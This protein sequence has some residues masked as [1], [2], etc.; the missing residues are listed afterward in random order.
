[1][2]KKRRGYKMKS[3]IELGLMIVVIV[4]LNLLGGQYYK[5][6][7]LTKEKRYT[8]S[9]TSKNL[10]AQVNEEMLIKVYL[11]GDVSP[12][13]K[14]LKNAVRD[15][16][17]EYRDLSEKNIVYEFKNP[18][19]AAGKDDQQGI[20]QLMAQKGITPYNDLQDKG[21]QEQSVKWIIPGAEVFYQGKEYVWNFL[22]TRSGSA[23]E[24]SIN[25]SIENLEYE[26]SNIL[27]KCVLPKKKKI[28]FLE[29]HGE[30]REE[31][32]ADFALELNDY[33]E[34]QRLNINIEDTSAM[35][36]YALII[37]EENDATK[38]IN[39]VQTSL[40]VFDGLVIAKPQSDITKMESYFIDQYIMKGGKVMWLIDPIIADMDSIE[41]YGKILAPSRNLELIQTQLFNY[42]VRMHNDILLDKT[43]NDIKVV[44]PFQQN[45]MRAFPWVYFPVFFPK[46]EHPIMRNLEGVWGQ[47]SS[48]MKLLS[49]ENLT[50]TPLLISSNGTK[51]AKAPATI[52]I[53][54]IGLLSNKEYVNSFTGGSQVSGALLEGEFPSY[55]ARRKQLSDIQLIKQSPK[56]KM[57]VISDGDIIRNHVSSK[58]EVSPLGF[59]R[60]TSRTFANKKFLLNCIDYLIDDSGLIEVRSKEIK[61]RLLDRVEVAE[62]RSFWQILNMGLPI[63]LILIFGVINSFIRKKKY[64]S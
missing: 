49:K 4:I 34:I 19:E 16:L 59:D 56:S 22:S 35:R 10:S 29:G 39:A 46:N 15:I 31:D 48:T 40:N 13:F 9:E 27:R 14:Q 47:F 7:D 17:N 57:I 28:A 25:G 32:V 36:R 38:L 51:V 50:S 24:E 5:R 58:G 23:K 60:N 33:Y 11:D 53:S 20:L 26:F 3:F 44:S 6:F 30:L 42:G 41:K 43:C 62:N 21:I 45:E 37:K 52:D 63:L 55:F 64:A 8:L 54:M 2:V 18:L 61:L 1:M 12:R